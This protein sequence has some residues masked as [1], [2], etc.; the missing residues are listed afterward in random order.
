M[1]E[2]NLPIKRSSSVNLMLLVPSLD[3]FFHSYRATSVPVA[4][5]HT[6]KFFSPCTNFSQVMNQVSRGEKLRALI[7]VG[8][9][10]SLCSFPVWQSTTWRP[11][12]G[13]AITATRPFEGA[14]FPKVAVGYDGNPSS[15]TSSVAYPLPSYNL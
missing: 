14:N 1:R 12:D 10:I 3:P 7:A 5:L 8:F 13:S 15:G 6:I 11:M 2:L 4:R 9:S